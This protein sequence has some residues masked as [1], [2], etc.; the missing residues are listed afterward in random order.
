MRPRDCAQPKHYVVT[1]PKSKRKKPRIVCGWKAV[2]R[3][4]M[5]DT[6]KFR[7][8]HSEFGA[9]LHLRNLRAD[10]AGRK[11]SVGRK[12][13]CPRPTESDLARLLRG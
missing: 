13:L 2:M 3:L 1:F 5:K 8:F 12:G 10:T 4:R 9:E 7:G 6:V 11:D